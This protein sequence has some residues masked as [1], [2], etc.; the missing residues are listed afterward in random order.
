MSSKSAWATKTVVSKTNKQ[1]NKQTKHV[2]ICRIVGEI[3]IIRSKIIQI[4]KYHISHMWL[5]DFKFYIIVCLWGGGG[6]NP[7]TSRRVRRGEKGSRGWKGT[8]EYTWG[9]G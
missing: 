3:K 9:E 6:G 1:T 7:E 4:Q 5:L 8:M 2:F